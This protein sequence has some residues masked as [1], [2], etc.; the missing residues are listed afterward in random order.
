VNTSSTLLMRVIKALARWRWR[1]WLSPCRLGRSVL[2][3]SC[4]HRLVA[5]YPIYFAAK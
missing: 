4:F 2:V 1:A 3:R 5:A